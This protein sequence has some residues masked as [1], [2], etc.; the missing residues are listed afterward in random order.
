MLAK[1]KTQSCRMGYKQEQRLDVR[2]T[3]TKILTLPDNWWGGGSKLT[4]VPL[5]G[6][7]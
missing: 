4:R 1:F 3:D 6:G 2:R 5:S 7:F